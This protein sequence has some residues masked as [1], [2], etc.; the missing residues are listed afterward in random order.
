MGDNMNTKSNNTTNYVVD[1]RKRINTHNPI[2]LNNTI[3]E[4]DSYE[5]LTK[6][7][8]FLQVYICPPGR[9]DCGRV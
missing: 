3:F 5:T 9:S 1:R 6:C 4:G 2:M 8:S 7:L